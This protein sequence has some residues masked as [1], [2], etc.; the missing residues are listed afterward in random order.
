ME[1]IF[2]PN[3]EAKGNEIKETVS[4][5]IAF[6]ECQKTQTGKRAVSKGKDVNSPFSEPF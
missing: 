3:D 4:W 5:F 1:K 6:G 2:E